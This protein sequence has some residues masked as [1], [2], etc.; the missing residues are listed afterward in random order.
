MLNLDV[1]KRLKEAIT[2]L[3]DGK[4]TPSIMSQLLER[5]VSHAPMP[6]RPKLE[7]LK[8]ARDIMENCV[9]NNEIQW[10][11][12]YGNYFKGNSHIIKDDSSSEMQDLYNG[13][14]INS[15]TY[16]ML[17]SGFDIF[18]QRAENTKQSDFNNFIRLELH[19]WAG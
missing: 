19:L 2:H 7:I 18:L 11:S 15:F 8:M 9:I 3:E 13:F 10:A 1:K 5:S 4:V 17:L 14:C 6:K 16:E 12:Q